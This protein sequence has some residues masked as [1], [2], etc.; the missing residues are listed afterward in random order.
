MNAESPKPKVILV[1]EHSDNSAVQIGLVY[2]CHGSTPINLSKCSEAGCEVVG[3]WGR[4]D[5]GVFYLELTTSV[6]ARQDVLTQL[7]E[8]QCRNKALMLEHRLFE[9]RGEPSPS[10]K[11][12]APTEGSTPTLG[13]SAN[14]NSLR[15]KLGRAR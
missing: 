1:L 14:L 10:G 8:E 11:H 13:T 9:P 3:T 15:A 12:R 7:I 5:E 2:D 6:E 4:L